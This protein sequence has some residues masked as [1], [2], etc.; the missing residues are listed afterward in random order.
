MTVAFFDLDNTLLA[1]D[2]DYLWGLYMAKVGAVDPQ[3]YSRESER[4]FRDY[5]A[6][7]LDVPAFLEFQL[8]PL[9]QN[10]LADLQ[11]WRGD[12]IESEIKPLMLPKATAL[13]EG[14]RAK[15]HQVVVATSTNSFITRPIADAFGIADLLATEPEQGA[16]GYTGAVSGEPCFGPG[17]ANR[18]KQWLAQ[19]KLSLDDSWFYTDSINDLPL[20]ELVAHPV[21]VNPDEALQARASRAGWPIVDLRN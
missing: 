15:S 2:S 18:V 6:G 13:I 8:K 14:H 21:A 3:Y 17:K 9:A 4:Y 5:E 16:S 7:A 1:G 11:R 20:L 10:S 19:E 12:F